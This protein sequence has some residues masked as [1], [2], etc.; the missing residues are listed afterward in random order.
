MVFNQHIGGAKV[1][2][3]RFAA[4]TPAGHRVSPPPT[5]FVVVN[6]DEADV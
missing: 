6:G 5:V 2:V 1:E 4:D 3:V